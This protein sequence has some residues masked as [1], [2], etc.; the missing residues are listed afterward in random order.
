MREDYKTFVKSHDHNLESSM[1]NCVSKVVNSATVGISEPNSSMTVDAKQMKTWNRSFGD[2]NT[3]IPVE[4]ESISTR[5]KSR[6]S[7]LEKNISHSLRKA[8]SLRKKKTRDKDSENSRVFMVARISTRL[9]EEPGAYISK[10]KGPGKRFEQARDASYKAVISKQRK[11]HD[12]SLPNSSGSSSH[13]KAEYISTQLRDEPSVSVS[14][15]EVSRKR[16]FEEMSD[17]ATKAENPKQRKTSDLNFENVSRSLP[18]KTEC[19]F[20]ELPDKSDKCNSKNNLSRKSEPSR[21]RDFAVMKNPGSKAINKK[22]RKMCNLSFQNSSAFA[23]VKA[24]CISVRLLGTYSCEIESSKK[25]CVREPLHDAAAEGKLDMCQLL[26][27]KGAG[28][29]TL[30]NKGY[31]PLHWAAKRGQICVA[32]Y[33]LKK[34]AN[35]HLKSKKFEDCG[36]TPLHVAAAQGN[37][38]MCQLLVSKGAD[39]HALDNKRLAPLHLAVKEEKIFE[40]RKKAEEKQE[41]VKLLLSKRASVGAADKDGLKPKGANINLKT[42]DKWDSGGT[43]LHFAASK[44][45]FDMCRLLVSKGALIDAL[46][47][48]GR[49]PLHLAVRENCKRIKAG[50][51]PQTVKL[52]ISRGASTDILDK[53]GRTPLHYAAIDNKLDCCHLLVSKGAKID[54]SDDYTRKTPLHL[55]LEHGLISIA[56]YLLEKGA[57]INLKYGRIANRYECKYTPLHFA[58]AKFNLDMCQFL[59]SKGAHVNALDDKGC[60]PLHWALKESGAPRDVVEI[61]ELLLSK[62]ASTDILDKYGSAPLHYATRYNKLN[63][64]HLLVSKGAQIDISDD[65]K[66][67]TPL[68]LA[69]ECGY[70]SIASYLLDKGANINLKYGGIVSRYEWKY[71]P[72]HFAVAEFNLDMC[73]FLLSKGAHV[74]VLDDNRSTPLHWAVKKPG[75]QRDKVEI[76]EL[77]LSNGAHVDALDDERRTPLHWALKNPWGPRDNVE[78]VEMLLSKGVSIHASDHIGLTPLHHAAMK[79]NLHV[80]MLLVSEG[81]HINALDNNKFT[82]LHWA[83]D[84]GKISAANY[85]LEKGANINLKTCNRKHRGQTPLHFAAGQGRL[86]MCRLLVSKGALINALDVKKRTPLHCAVKKNDSFVTS[87]RGTVFPKAGDKIKIVKLLLSRGATVD[88]LDEDALTPLAIALSDRNFAVAEYLLEKKAIYQPNKKDKYRVLLEDQIKKCNTDEETTMKLY[89]RVCNLAL[90]EYDSLKSIC[91]HVIVNNMCHVKLSDWFD[92][93]LRLKIFLTFEEELQLCF[94]RSPLK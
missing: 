44:G 6:K 79:D 8:V 73:Q 31:T 19:S 74:D 39:I 68:H 85:L 29:D 30:D 15:L 46:D 41:I 27:S 60:T 32:K 62:G 42:C 56:S 58:V 3:S 72:L 34:G 38:G 82:P 28:I 66:R 36:Q 37:I 1:D 61:I 87:F 48:D 24:K 33:L 88:A 92:M 55:A 40:T 86:E 91:R 7:H 35:L 21:K 20:A 17:P 4:T 83:V 80:C 69:L 9:H 11:S 45:K 54:I 13:N 89:S 18:I 50:D 90:N 57:N 70:I 51:K 23:P 65:Y 12:L 76:V 2:T 59:L 52:L 22:K 14:K 53:H 5:L 16:P 77:L 94:K 47:V 81:A 49:T 67:T 93:P 43:P 78:I 10:I 63:C 64:C 26:L 75:F 71:A 25:S 84:N